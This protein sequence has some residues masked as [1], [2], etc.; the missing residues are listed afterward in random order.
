MAADSA[1]EGGLS[2]QDVVFRLARGYRRP[3]VTRGSGLLVV[4]IL[5]AVV[6]GLGVIPAVAWTVAGFF[7]VLALCYAARYAWI[8]RFRT[9]LSPRGIEIRGYFD[10]FVPWPD[11][12]G[13]EV[14]SR[15]PTGLLLTGSTRGVH[16]TEFDPSQQPR[17]S[18]KVA[19]QDASNGLVTVRVA[20]SSGHRLLLRA[21]IV[22]GWQSDPEFEDKVATIRW[23]WQAY[24]RAVPGPATAR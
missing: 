22:T 21:P 16:V 24:G 15:E 7:A 5:A 2:G 10:H 3:L 23:W 8:G 11:V 6:A 14:T 4:A 18:E 13:V 9:R 19:G 17:T 1:G 12:T 20:R